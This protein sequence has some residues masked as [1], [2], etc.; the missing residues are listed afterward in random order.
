VSGV[1]YN[2]ESVASD[3]ADVFEDYHKD[4]AEYCPDCGEGC[5][6]FKFGEYV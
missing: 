5:V 6:G 2:E 1:K 4:Y 3:L